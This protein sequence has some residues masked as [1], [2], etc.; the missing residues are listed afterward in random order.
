MRSMTNP[1]RIQR[2]GPVFVLACAA[3]VVVATIAA[4]S[5]ADAP[6]STASAAAA[7]TAGL[8]LKTPGGSTFKAAPSWTARA[9]PQGQVLTA[10]E[11]DATIAIVDAAGADADAA[12]ADAWRAVQTGPVRPL[13][14]VTPQAPR[15]GWEERRVATY[16]S[17]PN[18]RMTV[19]AFA[20]RAGARWVVSIV[21]ASDATY[22]KRGAQVGLV[23]GS[24]RPPGYARE[25]FAGK[26]AHPLDAARI[27]AL[28]RLRRSAVCRS[29]ACRAS[30]GPDRSRQGG[31]RRRLRRAR[32]RPPERGR[33]RH[34][35]HRSRPTPRR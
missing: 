32:A 30:A 19:L 29:S 15:N 27:E 6:A 24:L 26:T 7:P 3:G 4:A 28:T 20:W 34:A 16:E 25:T 1:I 8:E 31:V 12:T 22:E 14:V 9:V 11:G 17:S 21:Q 13:R 5:A 18:E 2:R 35:V 23:L 33:R 10:P